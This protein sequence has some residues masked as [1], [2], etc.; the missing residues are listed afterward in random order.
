MTLTSA[1]PEI[2]AVSGR[3]GHTYTVTELKELQA[4]RPSRR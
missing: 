4:S 2:N 3:G 1:T